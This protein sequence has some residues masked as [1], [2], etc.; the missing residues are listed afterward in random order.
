MKE[1]TEKIIQKLSETFEGD[2][3]FGQSLMRKLENVPYIIGYK[4]CVPDSHSVAEIVAH[5]I[6][7]KKFVYEKL[8]NNEDFDITIDS[9]MDWPEIKIH[10]KKEWEELKR[11]LVSAQFRIYEA[12]REKPDDSYLS[13]TVTGREYD[14]EY[15]ILGI[16]QHDVYHLGLI[17]FIE[18]QLNKTESDSGVFKA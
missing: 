14:M 12:L 4:T 11:D 15:L 16:L 3:W 17:G 18:S 1:R 5:L 2:P 6:C 9:E 7:W 10:S 13:A 8:K